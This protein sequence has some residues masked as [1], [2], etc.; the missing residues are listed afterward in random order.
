MRHTECNHKG[1]HWAL[2]KG[3]KQPKNNPEWL[4]SHFSDP[5]QAAQYRQSQSKPFEEANIPEVATKL[6]SLS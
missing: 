2:A 1:M 4:R 3:G 5:Q 6:L